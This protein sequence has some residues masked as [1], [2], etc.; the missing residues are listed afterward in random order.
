MHARYAVCA[1]S[2]A[3]WRQFTGVSLRCVV[4]CVRCP[5]PLG[6]CSGMCRCRVFF[7]VCCGVLRFC[8]SAVVLPCAQR[9]RA[10]YALF[11]FR[12]ACSSGRSS[13]LDTW[14]CAVVVAGGLPL[15]PASWPH[16][17][18][19][20]LVRWVALDAHVRFSFAV[21]PSPTRG[22]P[23][24]IFWA[25]MWGTW[26]PAENWARGACRSPPPRRG[27]WACSA[28][29]PVGTPRW[30]CPWRVP[31]ALAS[32]CVRCGGVARVDPVSHASSLSYRPSLDRG[33]GQCTGAALWR[34]RHL[35]ILG[36]WKPRRRARV[37]VFVVVF[38]RVC[39]VALARLGS[40]LAGSGGPAFHVCVWLHSPNLAASWP[41]WTRWPTGR[42]VVRLT[43]P[44]A[45]LSTF[46]RVTPIVLDLT[47]ASMLTNHQFPNSK[48]VPKTHP[49]ATLGNGNQNTLSTNS[50][51]GKC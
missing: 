37:C 43:V 16:V 42:V 50:N 26:R 11:C 21:V 12:R 9:G 13:F 19:P 41:A 28:W 4:F 6:S 14:S 18:A 24:W 22:S 2:L 25:A 29:Y 35:Q 23:S 17:G 39:V 32:G 40:F 45:G 10:P 46:F 36:R 51:S 31:L 30:G 15:W 1:V 7:V 47:N 27:R 3:T 49:L 20:C 33:L 44:V 8:V 48:S 38:P 5:W 34:R